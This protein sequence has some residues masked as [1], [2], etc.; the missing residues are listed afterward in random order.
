MGPC[1]CLCEA[2]KLRLGNL[3]WGGIRSGLLQPLQGEKPPSSSTARWRPD[4]ARHSW[5]W[6]K[7]T[8]HYN[9]D[10]SRSLPLILALSWGRGIK[11][12]RAIRNRDH[13]FIDAES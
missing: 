11:G 6:A 10:C 2:Q 3:E 12:K 9:A 13:W 5:A 1:F 4:S 7:V 8:G